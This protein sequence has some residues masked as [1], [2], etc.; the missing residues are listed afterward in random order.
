MADPIK[1]VCSLKRGCVE[2]T[3]ACQDLESVTVVTVASD[4]AAIGAEIADADVL[5]INNAFYTAKLAAVVHEQ[6]RRLQWIQFYSTGYNNA[7]THGLP[8]GVTLTNAGSVYAP[9]VAEHA[10][11]LGA[12]SDP[13]DPADRTGAA[14]KAVRPVGGR[15]HI[16]TRFEKGRS[17][18]SDS[19]ASVRRPQRAHV[20]S[21]C[22]SSAWQAANVRIPWQNAL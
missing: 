10:M 17:W 22:A 21:A 11:A 4:A 8:D 7:E 16:S 2:L 15:L 3:T 9:V 18:P 20:V 12:R 1:I 5:V 14:A 13:A 19:A 6:A